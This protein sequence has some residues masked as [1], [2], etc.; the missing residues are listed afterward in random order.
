MKRWKAKMD[1][2][3]VLPTCMIILSLGSAV[4]YALNKDK[5]HTLYWLSSALIIYSVTF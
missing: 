2:T 4:V 1:A 5:R 3:K